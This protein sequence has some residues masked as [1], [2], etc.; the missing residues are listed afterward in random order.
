MAEIEKEPKM[1]MM[2]KKFNHPNIMSCE[3]WYKGCDG[4]S[5]ILLTKYEKSIT[6]REFL[7]RQEKSIDESLISYIF[8]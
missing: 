7:N 3:T 1:L 8:G 4:S 5:V 2:L 6:L